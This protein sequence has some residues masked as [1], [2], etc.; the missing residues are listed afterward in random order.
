MRKVFPQ[1]AVIVAALVCALAVTPSRADADDFALL[2]HPGEIAPDGTGPAAETNRA[3]MGRLLQALSFRTSGAAFDILLVGPRPMSCASASACNELLFRRLRHVR[4]SLER[5]DAV[6]ARA[7][8]DNSAKYAGELLPDPVL[9]PVPASNDALFVRTRLLR[10]VRP[11]DACPWTVHVADPAL[12]PGLD[13][14]P[15]DVQAVSPSA[16]PTTSASSIRITPTGHRG[17]PTAVLW[18]G[19]GHFVRAASSAAIPLSAMAGAQRLHLIVAERSDHP[20]LRA[21]SAHGTTPTPS[22]QLDELLIQAS[23]VTRKGF[24]DQAS[25]VRVEDIAPPRPAAEVVLCTVQLQPIAA[26]R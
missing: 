15:V 22:P 4:D 9:P 6:A 7:L 14:R 19:N 2:Y 21:A 17:R 10:P 5:R 1:A 26:V 20:L 23:A 12:P 11:D 16:L 24:G 18:E 25:R 8:N 13:G 3:A